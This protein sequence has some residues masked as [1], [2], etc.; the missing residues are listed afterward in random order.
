MNNK[1]GQKIRGEKMRILHTS[2]WHL[3]RSLHGYSLIE[4]QGY[5]LNKILEVIKTEGIDLLIIAG[6]IYDKTIPSEAAVE[7][8]NAFLSKVILEYKVCTIAI[9]GNHDSGERID[10]GSSLFENQGLYIVGKC[11]KGYKRITVHKNQEEIDVYLIPYIEPAYV[12][13]IAQDERIKRHDD[14]IGYLVSKIKEEQRKVP[15]LIVAHAFVTGG[16]GSDSERRLS[17]VG[18][19]ELVDAAHFKDFTYTALGHLHKKQA[20]GAPHIRYSGSLLKYST[21]E[22]KQEKGFV[23]VDIKDKDHVEIEERTLESLR[24]VR[25]LT[26]QLEDII[27]SS[28]EDTHKEDYVYARIKGEP[29]QDVTAVLRHIYPNI[30]GSEWLIEDRSIGEAPE[31]TLGTDFLKAKERTVTEVFMEFL[32][33]IDEL[34]FD[35]EETTYIEE[36]VGEI[37]EGKHEA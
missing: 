6:D 17:V 15:T 27:S 16:D 2:D 32:E 11:D 21:S 12:R 14:G 8:F 33:Y 3:G 28:S 30:L 7:L 35:A 26:G 4:D 37:E 24:D 22:A 25:I 5:V 1:E 34:D 23:I 29:V 10:F 18:G 31:N 13:E 9:A 19:A 36:I 20:M